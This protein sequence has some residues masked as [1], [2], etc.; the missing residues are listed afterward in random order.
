M[1][2]QLDLEATFYSREQSTLAD[3]TVQ[4]P[5]TGEFGITLQEALAG[6]SPLQCAVDPNVIHLLTEFTLRLWDGQEVSAKALDVGTDIKGNRIDIY[7]DTNNEA[8]DLGRQSVIAIFE[9]EDPQDPQD[10]S[11]GDDSDNQ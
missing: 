9:V 7:V 2:T 11:D 3:G 4:L 6:Q 5:A 8:I 10:A 1:S